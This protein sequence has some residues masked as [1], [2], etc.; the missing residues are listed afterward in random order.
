MGATSRDVDPG[1]GGGPERMGAGLTDVG[2]Q[3]R[4]QA[5]PALQASKLFRCYMA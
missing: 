3:K 1:F 4:A 2:R 5:D